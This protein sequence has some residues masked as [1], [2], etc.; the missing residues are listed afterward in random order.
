M[1]EKKTALEKEWESFLRREKKLLRKYGRRKEPLLERK[2]QK[3]VPDSLSEK[4]EAAF[5]RAFCMILE[6]GTAAIE[7]TFPKDRLE[8]EYKTREYAGTVYPVRKN[9]AAG[10]KLAARNAAAGV[11]GAC[12]EGAVLGL[13]G[14]GLPDIP[15]FLA[16]LLRSLY[17][18][19]LHFG[20]DYGKAE[21][22]VFLLELLALSLYNGDDFMEREAEMNRKIYRMACEDD[23][24][25]KRET[26]LKQ[27]ALKASGALSGELLY[28]KFLQGI[29]VAGLIGG[30]YDGI[31]MKKVTD[32]AAVKLERR[33]LLTKSEADHR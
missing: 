3:A 16:A 10:R 1:E 32:Y 20:V 11:A 28:M 8:A 33:Y 30:L 14:I 2:L 12:A 15:I 27:A 7:K 22:Q 4:L 5:Y 17:T 21:E 13:L 9:L 19:A 25:T 26:N 18:Q 29:P 6:N 31:Y 24:Q 23:S